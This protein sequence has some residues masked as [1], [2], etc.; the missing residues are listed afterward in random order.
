M[1]RAVE[2]VLTANVAGLIR[3]AYLTQIMQV[4][5]KSRPIVA[6]SKSVGLA[7]GKFQYPM[8]VTRPTVAEQATEK[9][10]VGVG[11]MVVNMVEV[12]AKT[13][14]TAANFSW[15]TVQWS[16]PDALSLWFDLAAESY[17]LKTDAAAAALVAAADSTPTAV[18]ANT[19]EAWT[20]AITAAAG[21]IYVNTG[22]YA[23]VIYADPVTAY[24]LLGMAS[25]VSPIFLSTGGG[26][27]SSGNLPSIGGLK[28]VASRGLTN[29]AIVAD[30]SALLTAE[31]PWAP[32][33][34]RA[35]EPSIGGIEVG[36]IG[37]FAA[38]TVEDAAFVELTPPA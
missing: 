16:N 33:D 15:Q 23:N 5:D 27:L 9:T 7:S 32:V 30:S 1:T 36:I 25:A 2:Q 22:R 4:I 37:A 6:T 3:P 11:T 34:L 28:I 17:A 12:V 21:D 29:M 38:E 19:I 8:I 13:Y 31:T 14:L 24:E 35:V 26:D 20:A 10:K 18:T